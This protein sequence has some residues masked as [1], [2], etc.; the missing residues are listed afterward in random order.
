M[1]IAIFLSGFFCAILGFGLTLSLGYGVAIAFMAYVG[2]GILG[3]VLGGV[4]VA[5]HRAAR[6][7][8]QIRLDDVATN[9]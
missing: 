8:Y 6:P 9:G 4:A 3:C 5:L 1:A 2:L 7:R